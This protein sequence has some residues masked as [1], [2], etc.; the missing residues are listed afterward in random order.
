[1]KTKKYIKF[2]PAVLLVPALFVGII[3]FNAQNNNSS[4]NN[5]Q[6]EFAKS[7]S[8]ND[9]AT[10]AT[11]PESTE[12]N[13]AVVNEENAQNA[14]THTTTYT[15]SNDVT[16]GA[17]E[18]TIPNSNIKDAKLVKDSDNKKAENKGFAAE[19]TYNIVNDDTFEYYREDTY[20]VISG[21]KEGVSVSDLTI[22][23]TIDGLP[24][25]GIGTKAFQQCLSIVKVNIPTS[26]IY[27]YS[28]AFVACD[29]IEEVNFINPQSSSLK[30]IGQEAFA[31]LPKLKSF[32]TPP[33]TTEIDVSAFFGDAALEKV[34]LN[35]GILKI[36]TG[37]FA[38][39]TKLQE[40]FIPNSVDSLGES[41][42]QGSGAQRV[43]VGSGMMIL[44]ENCFTEMPN[45]NSITF[46]GQYPSI[47]TYSPVCSGATPAIDVRYRA[48]Y[49]SNWKGSSFIDNF[50][51]GS[52][53]SPCIYNLEDFNAFCNSSELENLNT[54]FS[55]GLALPANGHKEYAV[56]GTKQLTFV[57]SAQLNLGNNC[58]TVGSYSNGANLT[59]N[60]EDGVNQIIGHISSTYYRP[61]VSVSTKPS[62]NATSPTQCPYDNLEGNYAAFN[63]SYQNATVPDLCD[64]VAIYVSS[65]SKLQINNLNFDGNN[66]AFSCVYNTGEFN[67]D[68]S[69]FTNNKAL[70]DDKEE[71]WG[72]AG[73]FNKGTATLRLCT[74]KG[75]SSDNYAGALLNLSIM[76]LHNCTVSNNTAVQAGGG[77]YTNVMSKDSSA[78]L[79][80]DDCT[81]NSNSSETW[82]GGVAITN[83]VQ[84]TL[85]GSTTSIL[86]NTA[87]GEADDLL[88]ARSLANPKV[89]IP[90]V[91]NGFSGAK[92]SIGVKVLNP[93]AKADNVL[94]TGSG[95][96]YECFVS[97]NADYD[98]ANVDGNIV[99]KKHE[100]L[101]KPA[102]KGVVK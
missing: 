30:I 40:L 59:I 70:F 15:L 98:I 67:A 65:S 27:I 9:S 32:T 75:N 24:V 81:I 13:S 61:N 10:N 101:L 23:N 5:S 18:V 8:L 17:S 2:L 1:M 83:D 97:E 47:K 48:Y 95:S 52:T 82:G 62:F 12:Q 3:G 54:K 25:G 16:Q 90:F 19:N 41:A 99:M 14:Q 50:P 91:L 92:G 68:N 51:S 45:L 73:V 37:A 100:A 21:F 29:N 43:V 4:D 11:S 60:G 72:A 93:D 79:L 26:V 74:F 96:L 53:L 66:M 44:Y 76:Q 88:M 49:C 42:L 85:S 22:P 87:K 6:N 57:D 35:E 55:F 39:T 63:D 31:S 89:V 78:S 102:N 80:I 36:G 56:S 20:A 58:L 71:T 69:T 77:V 7:L 34:E 64:G 33:S 46:L 86:S 84:L 38:G 94:C 28:S